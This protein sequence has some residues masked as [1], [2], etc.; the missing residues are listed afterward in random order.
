MEIKTP[1]DR[2]RAIIRI[3]PLITDTQKVVAQTVQAGERRQ[4]HGQTD[5]RYRVHYLPRFAVDN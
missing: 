4:T 3:R 5:G 2:I 1:I